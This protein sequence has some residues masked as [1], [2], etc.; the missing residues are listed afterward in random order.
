MHYIYI[1]GTS[2]SMHILCEPGDLLLFHE[3]PFGSVMDN[4]W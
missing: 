2:I 1:D 3:L 4:G